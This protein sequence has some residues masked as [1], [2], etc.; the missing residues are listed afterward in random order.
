MRTWVWSPRTN[1]KRHVWQEKTYYLSAGE[2]ETGVLVSWQAP[3]LMRVSKVETI[4]EG[5]HHQPLTSKYSFPCT[6][7]NPTPPFH[8]HKETLLGLAGSALAKHCSFPVCS[9]P[10]LPLSCSALSPCLPSASFPYSRLF[11]KEDLN[12]H[13]A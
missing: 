7:P 5:T 13:G 10:P 11:P 3:G 4:H 1:I 8:T 9:L 2:W 6:G 12:V